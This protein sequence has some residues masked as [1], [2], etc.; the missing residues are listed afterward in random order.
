M[1]SISPYAYPASSTPNMYCSW[2]IL[3]FF[4]GSALLS[5]YLSCNFATLTIVLVISLQPC[6]LHGHICHKYSLIEVKSCDLYH[7]TNHLFPQSLNHSH[8]CFNF[9][10]DTDFNLIAFFSSYAR[11]SILPFPFLPTSLLMFLISLLFQN[12][13]NVSIWL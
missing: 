13:P 7:V 1:H 11:A 2:E 5:M 10:T 3:H 12:L 9:L 8:L 6:M 4:S